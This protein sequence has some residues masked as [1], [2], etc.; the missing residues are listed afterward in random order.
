MAKALDFGSPTTNS[1]EIPGSTPG[2]VEYALGHFFLPFQGIVDTLFAPSV[3]LFCSTDELLV[4]ELPPIAALGYVIW[5][6][7]T[8]KV[9]S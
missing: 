1:L 9:S 6:V 8:R 5:Q 3:D 7:G 4:R 2:V